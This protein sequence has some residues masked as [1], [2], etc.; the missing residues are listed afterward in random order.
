MMVHII[1][2]IN[3]TICETNFYIFI[4][5]FSIDLSFSYIYFSIYFYCL[6]FWSM[7][8]LL[9][10]SYSG[11]LPVHENSMSILEAYLICLSII[12]INKCY[13]YHIS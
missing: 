5:K 1:I 4:F 3:I 8:V 2:I 6:I 12:V 7:S 11:E 13:Q 10:I 9:S